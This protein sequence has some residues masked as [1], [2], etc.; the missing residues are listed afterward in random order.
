MCIRSPSTRELGIL[1][2]GASLEKRFSSRAVPGV[3]AHPN[4]YRDMELDA[5]VETS[6]LP[7]LAFEGRPSAEAA[8]HRGEAIRVYFR[9]VHVTP[10][11]QKWVDMPSTSGQKLRADEMVMQALAAH[12]KG[13]SAVPLQNTPRHSLAVMSYLDSDPSWLRQNLQSHHLEGRLS[14]T[15]KRGSLQ[16]GSGASVSVPTDNTRIF[17]EAGALFQRLMS[18]GACS[19]TYVGC[20]IPVSDPM[21][22]HALALCN[23][24]VLQHV[25]PTASSGASYTHQTSSHPHGSYH[26]P[27]TSEA[28]TKPSVH[29]TQC[30]TTTPLKGL[31]QPHKLL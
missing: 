22:D 23:V 25:P 24:G 26:H 14:Y 10:S 18:A 1:P 31:G 6:W 29:S 27:S 8:E 28:C 3:G 11:R 7:S 20:K 19:G 15:L 21:Y 9:F 12:Q 2:G 30:S 4:S 17:E 5:D 16:R 13:S